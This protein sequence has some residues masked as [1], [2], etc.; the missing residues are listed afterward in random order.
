[1]ATDMASTDV[2]QSPGLVTYNTSPIPKAT[3]E[4]SLIYHAHLPSP[5]PPTRHTDGRQDSFPYGLCS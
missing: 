4:P 5:Q 3:A 1:M 2:R